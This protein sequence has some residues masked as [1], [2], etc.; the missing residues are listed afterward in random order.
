VGKRTVGV[1]S[2]LRSLI[3]LDAGKPPNPVK[4]LLR[5]A[6]EI[7]RDFGRLHRIVQRLTHQRQHVVKVIW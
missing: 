5:K 6:V 3:W 2:P 7:S 4:E 1:I